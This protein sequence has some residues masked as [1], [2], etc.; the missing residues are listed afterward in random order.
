MHLRATAG[1]SVDRS[2]THHLFGLV[3]LTAGIALAALASGGVA[4]AANNANSDASLANAADS[5]RD[6]DAA[7]AAAA[8]GAPTVAEGG[9]LQEVVVTAT[10]REEVISNIPISVTAITSQNIDA[11]GIKD[12]N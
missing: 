9:G 6:A 7:A 8:A 3:P 2:R 1:H 4:S 11:L 5:S 10:R 12:F